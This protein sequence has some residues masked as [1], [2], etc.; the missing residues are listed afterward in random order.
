MQLELAR[1]GITA[2]EMATETSRGVS[3]ITF[4]ILFI[5]M[6]SIT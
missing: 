1:F 2:R 5:V 4:I 6:E 3:S